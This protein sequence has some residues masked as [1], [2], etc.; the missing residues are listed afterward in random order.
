MRYQHVRV[1]TNGYTNRLHVFERG[2][3]SDL[4]KKMTGES[5]MTFPMQ[6]LRCGHVH[7]AS[8]VKVIGRYTDCSTWRCPQCDSL[9]DDRPEAWGGSARRVDHSFVAAAQAGYRRL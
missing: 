5:D 6:C 7:D 4:E 2:I 8:K 1:C 9:I 3:S